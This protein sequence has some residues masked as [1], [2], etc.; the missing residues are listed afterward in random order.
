MATS[1]VTREQGGI[2]PL[3]HTTARVTRPSSWLLVHHTGDTGWPKPGWSDAQHMRALQSFST[4]A[5]KTW[6]Y[7]YVITH[8]DGVIWEQAGEFQAAHCLNA[9]GFSYGVQINQASSAGPPP[10]KVVD[11]FRWL[12]AHLVETGQLVANHQCVPHYRLRAT[13]CSSTDLAEPPGARWASPTGEGSLGN[14]HTDLLAPWTS[15]VPMATPEEYAT[16]AWNYQ[17]PARNGFPAGPAWIYLA[18]ARAD[19]FFA[20]YINTPAIAAV[21][22]DVDALQAQA[23]R[24]EAL[25][26]QVLDA[27]AGADIPV[28]GNVHIGT[29]Q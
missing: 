4:G 11:S 5:G 12:R 14:V 18:D 19:A 3:G 28:I 10:Q 26:Q 25:L 7:N 2:V 16:A 29:P 8:P 9:N 21:Q 24:I 22:T 6:E 13:A 20:H 17:I 1:I 15:E 23:D 27:L